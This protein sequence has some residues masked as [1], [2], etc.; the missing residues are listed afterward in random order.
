MA[1]QEIQY[2][3]TDPPLPPPPTAPLQHDKRLGL[4][5]NVARTADF[6]SRTLTIYA[7]YK[8]CQVGAAG[9]PRHGMECGGG[10]VESRGTQPA[11]APR[12]LRAAG[13]NSQRQLL[14]A[15]RHAH[16]PTTLCC[17][18]MPAPLT[19]AATAPCSLCRRTRCCCGRRG[20]ARIA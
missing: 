1:A 19:A 5:E 16:R 18:T 3:A 10:L 2:Q 20:G 8:A 13:G 6:W 12:L 4:L 9:Q 7:G 14:P 17:T 11:E 15:Q